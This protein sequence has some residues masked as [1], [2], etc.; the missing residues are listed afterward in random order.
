[1][2]LASAAQRLPIA[3]RWGLLEQLVAQA[4]DANDHNLPLMYWYAA[5]PLAAADTERALAFALRAGET[6]PLIREYML[7][8]IGSLDQTESLAALVRGLGKAGDANLQVTFLKAIQASLKGQRSVAPPTE[9]AAVSKPLLA[10]KNAA[11]RQEALGLGVKFGD[12]AAFA[13][14]RGTVTKNEAAPAVRRAALDDLLA[15][16][17]PQLVPILFQSLADQALRDLAIRGLA[18][19]Q[20]A[21]TPPRLLELYGKLSS[22]DDKRAVLGTLASRGEYG[23][24]LLKA[25]EQ[26]KLPGTDLTADLVR[27][28]QYL[29]NDDVNRLLNEVWGTARETAADKVQMIAALKQLAGDITKPA[30]DLSLGRA[31]FHK[32]C[33]KCH[34][35]YGAGDK[36]GPDLTGSNR[37]DLDYLLSN[38]V[39]PSAVMAKE[40]QP[41]IVATQD[42]RVVS[43]L[44]RAEDDKSLTVQTADALVIV[45]KSEIDE[46]SIS[47]KSMMP[48]DQLKLF[49]EHETRSLI[50]YLRGRQQMAM[51]ATASNA[52]MMFNGK[53]LSGWSGDS[54]LWRVE[55]GELVGQTNGLK[56]NEWLVSDLTAED[57]RLTV[58][59]KLVDNAGNSGLQFRSRTV[60]EGDVAGYQADVGAGWWGKLYEEHGR[61]LLW[62]K[63]G[64]AHVNKG[65][66]NEYRIEARG[67]QIRTWI[68][69]QP[70]VDLDD[71]VG[72][73]RGIFALQLH[74]GG[75]TEVRYRNFQLEVL[76]GE[77]PSTT[78]EVP[79]TPK[80]V[81]GQR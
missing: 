80:P 49:S 65:D 53:S 6:I 57:F 11:V 45:P 31:I 26:K 17:D 1:L 40:Y 27:Q 51:L 18:Q 13:E 66:W 34:V 42:G 58:Q 74:S 69:G 37:S 30:A 78:A 14:F 21:E 10:S 29:K 61:A 52:S 63:S 48:D 8:R 60:G 2:A 33:Q 56:R 12:P 79:T 67:A 47:T 44:V 23:V 41:V 75:K 19:Y 62:D 38:M 25:V 43:G 24:A 39:D 9:W 70:C 64:E 15:A 72:A 16:K 81:V 7:R 55:D 54:A 50:A 28:L 5:E 59:V 46:R 4:E 76:G 36:I 35:L 22:L 20:D 3:Q 71:P 77:S 32:T 68:N 73:K